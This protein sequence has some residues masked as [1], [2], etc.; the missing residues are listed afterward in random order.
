MID[1]L[2]SG[3]K[4]RLKEGDFK[5]FHRDTEG[6]YT[7]IDWDELNREIDEVCAEFKTQ[8]AIA[9]KDGSVVE[10]IIELAEMDPERDDSRHIHC[11][12]CW[13]EASRVAEP[14]DG[15]DHVIGHRPGCLWLRARKLTELK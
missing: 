1:L 14:H 10:I 12:F 15:P 2:A 3:L 11:M 4:V 9:S 13:G 5:Q 6:S 7:E 8:N